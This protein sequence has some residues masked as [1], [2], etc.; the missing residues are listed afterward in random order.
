MYKKICMKI[1]SFTIV[2][3][4]VLSLT[5]FV[6]AENTQQYPMGVKQDPI[7][8]LDVENEAISSY[9]V[10]NI[11]HSDKLP[12]PDDQGYQSSCVGWA[13]SYL[14]SFYDG[15][16][17]NK[18]VK[19][20]PSFVYNQ[21]NGGVDCGSYPS[22]AMNLLKTFGICKLENMP[23]DESDFLTLPNASQFQEAKYYKIN[24]WKYGYIN[25]S[26]GINYIKSYLNNNVM[27]MTIP[28]F[29]D[30][31]NIWEG[32]PVYDKIQGNLYGYHAITIVGY[33]DKLKAFKFINS[34]GGNWGLDGYGYISY[35][36]VKNN[37]NFLSYIINDKIN[38]DSEMTLYINNVKCDSKIENNKMTTWI[39]NITDN[40][41][42]AYNVTWDNITKTVTI[43][44]SINIVEITIGSSTMLVNGVP[45][46]LENIPY[47][48]NGKTI[49]Q[50]RE[51]SEALG[52]N[53]EWIKDF[54][55][56][57]VVN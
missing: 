16:E 56:V 22:D 50:V 27:L 46:I 24:G 1:L 14:K 26:S 42:G 49:V 4:F 19:F 21:I 5:T 37:C 39:R 44:D 8:S 7:K 40:L 36:L 23:Y 48:D 55:Y 32:N 33:N 53:V 43:N 38:Q 52:A 15:E 2:I 31:F 10:D 45:Q 13:T 34:W 35:E 28:V 18:I 30:F 6:F 57:D 41:N 11:D 17:L 54:K 20:S 47:L 9:L 25:N 51:I 12:L 29:S 3:I